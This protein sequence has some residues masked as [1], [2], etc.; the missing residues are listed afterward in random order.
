MAI[1][2]IF[3]LLFISFLSGCAADGS[4]QMPDLSKYGFG[5]EDAKTGELIKGCKPIPERA[6]QR[7][8]KVKNGEKF[9]F[10]IPLAPKE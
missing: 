8:V 9:F 1:R 7:C 5:V 6:V 3:A 2:M 10:E 4:F